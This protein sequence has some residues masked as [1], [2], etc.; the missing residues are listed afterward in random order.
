[1]ATMNEA[2]IEATTRV[3]KALAR[4]VAH[5]PLPVR[6]SCGK[7]PIV[8][9]LPEDTV[10]WMAAR[11]ERSGGCANVIVAY[12]EFFSVAAFNGTTSADAAGEVAEI[13]HLSN[14]DM[15]FTWLREQPDGKGSI[16]VQSHS[17]AN[18]EA[19]KVQEHEYAF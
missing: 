14:M 3:M 1:M 7:S 5:D 17:V 12:P 6:T 16:S 9:T 11:V 19:P 4:L 2:R 10:S 18:R 8:V 13:H 15:L